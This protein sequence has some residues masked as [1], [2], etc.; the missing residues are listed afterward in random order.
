VGFTAPTDFATERL[1][2]E[3]IRD[4][5]LGELAGMDGDERTMSTLGG[6][7]SLE[8]TRKYVEANVEHWRRH[9]FGIWILRCTTSGA[10]LGRAGLR[11]ID[12]SGV[13]ET[14]LAYAFHHDVWGRGLATEVARTLIAIGFDTLHF[15]ELI[16]FTLASNVA[17]MRVM[18]KVGFGFERH[19]LR[20][21]K[22]HV[23]YRLARTITALT[24]ATS[25]T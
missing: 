13:E 14:E 2:A 18:E 23:L 9:G 1:R 10:F 17:S 25:Q 15:R 11:R 20:N 3:R 16:A 24:D 4:D 6:S 7:R 21:G 12:L 22:D 19:F 8:Q 5:H